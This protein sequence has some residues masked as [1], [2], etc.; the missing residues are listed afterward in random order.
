MSPEWEP[1]NFKTALCDI[2][3]AVASG[4]VTAITRPG[5]AV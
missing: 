5:A 2:F 1:A 3:A 4:M